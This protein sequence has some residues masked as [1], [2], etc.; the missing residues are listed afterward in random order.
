M[1]LIIETKSIRGHNAFGLWMVAMGSVFGLVFCLSLTF[2]LFFGT[3]TSCQSNPSVGKITICDMSNK[4]R[5]LWT[6]Y[7]LLA[8]DFGPQLDSGFS[9]KRVSLSNLD[10]GFASFLMSKSAFIL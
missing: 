2:L 3:C 7:F 1:L 4:L 6:A 9:G 10:G 8:R 5:V